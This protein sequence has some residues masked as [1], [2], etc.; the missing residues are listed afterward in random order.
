VVEPE[1]LAGKIDLYPEYTGVIVSAL[2]NIN[3]GA[4]GAVLSGP[5]PPKSARQAY[6]QA[7]KFE[8]ERGFRLL[9]P[10]PGEDTERIATL[11]G[12]ARAHGLRTTSDLKRLASFS[13]G[14]PPE[15]QTRYEGIVGMRQAYGLD[16]VR[17]VPY[18]IGAQ[19]RALNR[20]RV[21][22]IAV[23]TT[24]GQLLARRY[25]LLSDPK[26]LFGFQHAAPVVRKSVLKR[27][28]PAFAQ[29]LNAVSGR[30]TTRVMQRLNAEVVLE[31]RRPAAVAHRFLTSHGLR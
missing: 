23:F 27:E 12:F 30:L 25:A 4:G 20:H 8:D 15:N 18:A 7:A 3:A 14:G 29:T 1:L 26:N 21:Q 5:P 11:P 31:H 2:A 17:F 6:E 22:T 9:Q 19:Y 16:N 13:N 28:G 10:T 24:D